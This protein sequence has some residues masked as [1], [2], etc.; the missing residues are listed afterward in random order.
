M[1]NIP[2]QQQR[3]NAIHPLSLVTY[4]TVMPLAGFFDCMQQPLVVHCEQQLRA[5]L[6]AVEAHR[7]PDDRLVHVVLADDI[8]LTATLEP[9]VPVQISGFPMMRA[10]GRWRA[11]RL[12]VEGAH[13]LLVVTTHTVL[14]NVELEQCHLTPNSYMCAVQVEPRAV[15]VM[16]QCR[17]RASGSAVRIRNRGQVAI[18]DSE[19]FGITSICTDHEQ[20]LLRCQHNTLAW[21]GEW[22]IQICG[23]EEEPLVGDYHKHNTIKRLFSP[24]SPIAP[25]RMWQAEAW[26]GVDGAN[27]DVEQ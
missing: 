22:P 5:A 18:S 21:Y 20:S 7:F 27:P 8:Q 6:D 25:G 2:G 3:R 24:Q 19:L 9:M 10:D 14:A 23:R 17:V 11:P 26:F 12:S 4:H 16:R 13:A 15:L 1:T